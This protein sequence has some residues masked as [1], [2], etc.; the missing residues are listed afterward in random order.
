MQR[1]RGLATKIKT[2][3]AIID[4]RRPEPGKSKVMNIIGEVKGKNC[5]IID[6]IIELS[7]QKKLK[8]RRVELASLSLSHG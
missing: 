1:T 5:I 3:L 7:A 8:A 4:K 6:D 2:D